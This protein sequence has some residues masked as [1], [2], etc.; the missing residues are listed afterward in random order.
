MKPQPFNP[1]KAQKMIK[2]KN[3]T[4]AQA[5]EWYTAHSELWGEG[6]QKDHKEANDFIERLD[7]ENGYIEGKKQSGCICWVC[8]DV[9]KRFAQK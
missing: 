4:V 6:L 7:G 3:L 2:E 9:N 8:M 1:V 5:E